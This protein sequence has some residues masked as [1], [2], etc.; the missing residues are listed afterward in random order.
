MN[1]PILE[2][3]RDW[4]WCINW[5]C[6]FIYRLV[7]LSFVSCLLRNLCT[8]S[9]ILFIDLVLAGSSEQPQEF[10]CWARGIPGLS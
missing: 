8:Y 4:S 9:K 7:N 3:N 5:F 10:E 2:M 6:V 1:L